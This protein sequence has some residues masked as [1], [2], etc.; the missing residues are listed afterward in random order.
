MTPSE[1][2][3]QPTGPQPS[4]PMRILVQYE[5]ELANIVEKW[6]DNAVLAF[7][8]QS[9]AEWPLNSSAQRRL[10]DNKTKKNKIS[11]IEYLNEHLL[12]PA[13]REGY[14]H[15]ENKKRMNNLEL[16][17]A[18]QHQGAATCLIDFTTNFHIA[19][20]FAC[21]KAKDDKGCEKDGKIFIINHGF[22]SKIRDIDSEKKRKSVRDFLE[23]FSYQNRSIVVD[24]KNTKESIEKILEIASS[25]SKSVI[26]EVKAYYWKPPANK[27]RVVAQYSCFIFTA[28]EPI[29]KELY[30]EISIEGRDKEEIF[31]LLEKYYDLDYESI[32][33]DFTGFASSHGLHKP[34]KA[35]TSREL[36]S[37]AIKYYRRGKY[38]EAVNYCTEAIEIDSNYDAA[39]YFRSVNKFELN[40]Y[41]EAIKD[42]T[43]AIRFNSSYALYF[44]LRGT[45]NIALSQYQEAVKDYTQAITIKSDYAKAYFYRGLAKMLLEQYEEAIEDFT[46]AITIKPDYAEAYQWRGLA[47]KG[48]SNL[49]EAWRDLQEALHLA[50]DQSNQS[51][52]ELV[53]QDLNDLP[54]ENQKE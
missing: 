54:P 33:R 38:Q 15:Q 44:Y 1:T 51:V 19:L 17:A 10:K 35:A 8:G 37:T 2:T 24:P 4:N 25:P 40:E 13:R 23:K 46:Q 28:N 43:E 27:N 20:W 14:D 30:E 45:I 50:T 11:M 5:E 6:G 21:Q 32:F 41:Q 53:R 7:R 48:F 52:I 34:I 47:H 9:D 3:P 49:P 22:M 29:D 31:S 42:L 26:S 18:L 36:V 39:Y 12:K 16:L